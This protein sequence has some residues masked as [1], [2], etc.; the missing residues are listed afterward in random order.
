MLLTGWIGREGQWSSVHWVRT[1]LFRVTDAAVLT[2][3]RA[4]AEYYEQVAGAG[5]EPKAAAN[6]VMGEVLADAKDH[7]EAL[8]VRH[9][10]QQYLGT[11]A[12]MPKLPDERTDALLQNVI[13]E[14]DAHRPPISE[15]LG[16]P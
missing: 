13:A 14:H 6:W 5:A 3:E 4:V 16:Q 10:A 11:G 1:G 2:A 9:L 7:A 12:L 8:R 15:V